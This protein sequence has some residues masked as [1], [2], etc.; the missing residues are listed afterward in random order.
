MK[1][2]FFVL[3]AFSLVAQEEPDYSTFSYWDFHPLHAGGNLIAIGHADV[4]PR[5]GPE[6]G[7]LLF[8]KASAF[9][10][11]LVPVSKSTYF[12][13]RVE[14]NTFTMDWNENPKFNQTHFHYMQF[15]LTFYSTAVETW[16]WISRVDYNL[17]IKHASHPGAY[18]LFSVL[19]WGTHEMREKWH[20]HLGALGYTGLEGETVYPVVGV[21]Y[22]PNEKW[23]LQAVFPIT[24]SIEYAL[25]KEWRLSLK[26]RPLKERFRTGP[27]EPQPRS[28]FSYT[29]IGTELNL[30]YEKFLRVEFEIFAGYNFGGNFYIKNKTGAT[31]LYTDLSG[32]P[33]GGATLNWGF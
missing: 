30:H 22:T 16:R 11:L 29:S 10:Q 18:G 24:Y 15:A 26:G 25:T 21:D 14:W 33:Y 5:H 7:K 17:D 3:F 4:D 31:P 32:A 23:L 8:N 28:V 6:A 19:L 27:L 20:I 2:L 13:P 12:F 1:K 9:V